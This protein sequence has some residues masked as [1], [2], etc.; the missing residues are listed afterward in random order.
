VG[1]GAVAG[2]GVQGG[3]RVAEA[4]FADQGSELGLGSATA[5]LA[6]CGAAMS[7]V[8]SSARGR[9]ARLRG[10]WVS[11]LRSGNMS[12]G[13]GTRPLGNKFF[14]LS[15]ANAGRVIVKQTSAGAFDIVGKFQG[16][17]RGDAANSATIARLMGD[18]SGL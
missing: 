5:Y 9:R 6:P 16:H 3:A 10:R 4:T 11:F 2:V 18:Y 1:D 17:V 7:R 14:E 12:P 8:R 13:I 15:G